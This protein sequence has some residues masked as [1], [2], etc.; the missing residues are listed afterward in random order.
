MFNLLLKLTGVLALKKKLMI[1]QN[2]S[3]KLDL[4]PVIYLIIMVLVFAISL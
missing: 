2:Q 4:S 3:K 1:K